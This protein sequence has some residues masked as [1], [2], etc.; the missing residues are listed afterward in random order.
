MFKPFAILLSLAGIVISS[1]ADAQSVMSPA[2]A[3]PASATYSA[4]PSRMPTSYGT[5]SYARGYSSPATAG[6]PTRS[7]SYSYYTLSPLPARTYVPYATN[8]FSFYGV[9]YGHP[10]DPWTWPMMS[11]YSATGLARYYDPPVK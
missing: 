2:H 9:P 7:Y 3:P 4:Y 11:G 6:Q 10:Y 1:R 5:M 8:D